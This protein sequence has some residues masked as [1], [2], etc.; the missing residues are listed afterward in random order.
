M[1]TICQSPNIYALILVHYGML[2]WAMPILELCR[3]SSDCVTFMSKIKSLLVFMVHVVLASHKS[4]MPLCPILSILNYLSWFTLICGEQHPLHQVVIIATMKPL[5]MHTLDTLE[6]T[7]LNIRVI[8]SH[9]SHS[10]K[11]M[12]TH[13]FRLKENPFS[14][15]L[16]G[17]SYP[18]PDYLMN[19]ASHID[20]HAHILHIRMTCLK[21]STHKLWK[22]AS[23]C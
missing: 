16:V 6:F 17:N 22:W 1:H 2:D 3:V 5:W 13:N 10:F 14:L 15:V 8:L 20:S 11:I 4:C 23:H 7:C 19:K 12:L 9:H 18:F 21:G